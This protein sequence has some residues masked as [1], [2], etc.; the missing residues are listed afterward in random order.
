MATRAEVADFLAQRTLALVGMSRGGKK[1]GNTV[2]RDLTAKG[3]TVL[4][5]HPDATEIGGTRCWPSLL[6]LPEPVGG[7]VIVVPPAETERVVADAERAGIRRVWMQQGSESP[8]AIR[9]CAEHGIGVVHGECILMF[10][11]PAGFVHRAHRWVQ[12]ILGKLP[13]EA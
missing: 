5:V 13:R 7:V 11:E 9:F 10:A 1:F 12:G 2:H 6:G 3:Y 4:P 8:Q